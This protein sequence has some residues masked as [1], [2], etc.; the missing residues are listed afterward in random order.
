MNVSVIVCTVNRPMVLHD[1]ILSVKQQHLLPKQIIIASPSAD[2]ILPETLALDGVEYVRTSL[3][4]C[5]QRNQALDAVH[6]ETDLVVFLD[7][8]IELGSRYLLEMERLFRMHPEILIASGRMLHDGGRSGRIDRAEARRQCRLYDESNASN[9]PLLLK[10]VD[11]G[12]G[13]NMAIRFSRIGACRF[14][15]RLPLYAWLEDRDF[16]HR[17]TAGAHPPVELQNAAAVHL[18]W[19]AGRVSGVR[20]GFS[21]VVNPIY[22][23][24]KAN[25]FSLSFIVVQYWA[26][27][28]AGNIL[29]ILTRDTEYDRVGL[30]KGN[31]LGF[32]HLLSGHCD[33]EHILQL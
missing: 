12:Y 9:A 28:L 31:L 8:D 20:L 16:S 23:K 26:R 6:P 24:R 32:H 10:D 25:T 14:D 2:H 33:P 5:K 15:E 13:C 19:R 22:L 30:L 7:D 1:T 18:G 11:S 4:L 27:C 17:Y 21:T 3:G 29:G